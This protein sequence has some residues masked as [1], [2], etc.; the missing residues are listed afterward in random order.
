MNM[1]D[2]IYDKVMA[3]LSKWILIKDPESEWTIEDF[4]YETGVDEKLTYPHCWKC[5][6][7]NHCWFYNTEEKKPEEFDYTNYS[8]NEIPL[9]KRGLYHPNCHC[10]KQQ[11]SEPSKEE[12]NLIIPEGKIWYLFNKK[13]LTVLSYMGYTKN[14]NQE[15][16][17]NLIYEN[18][19][20]SF[21]EGN[22]KIKTITR[23]GVAIT[24]Y[25]NFPGQ[26]QYNNKIYKVKSGWTIFPNGKI[27]ANTLLGRI[28]E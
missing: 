23:F 28:D 21:S 19:R 2:N 7:V 22:Y 20:K 17:L 25:Y 1:F 26:N 10:E 14:D 18:S 6:T 3:Q 8:Q 5:V 9:S 11:I 15:Q 12:I 13:L 24:L 4:P 27:K 16:I